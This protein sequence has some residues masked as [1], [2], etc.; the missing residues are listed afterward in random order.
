MKGKLIIFIKTLYLIAKYGIPKYIL[1]FGDSLG[2][3]LLLTVLTQKIFQDLHSTVWIK[4][5]HNTLFENNNTIKHILPYNLPLTS[6]ALKLFSIKVVSLKYTQTLKNEDRDESP[7]KN[8]VLIMADILNLKGTILN[9]P[10]LNL[11]ANE[12]QSGVIT[13]KQIVIVG[14]VSNALVAMK[15][16]E[17]QFE[18]YQQVINHFSE[19]YNFIQL[20]SISDP[21][22]DN[23]IDLR[24][25]TTIR[26]SAAILY[27][28][29]LL[30][31]YVGF[32]MHL[33][34]AVNCR[35]VILYGGREHPSQS[36]YTCNSNIYTN[37][38]CSPCWIHNDCKNNMRCMDLISVQDVIN[39]ATY[40]IS[41]TQKPL[42]VD[43]LDNGN[44]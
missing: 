23:V 3:N 2:D 10:T 39:A 7:P 9:K 43:F 42:K 26:E 15:T 32:M 38:E 30:I 8:I 19:Q 4:S 11:L 36:G 27:N 22:F 31:S 13:K 16:K 44:D 35:S 37:L 25:K 29:I 40:Q 12:K 24:G 28:S 21:K 17:W 5:N 14:S 1:C 18:R 20:G 6:F 34:R 41:Q 33:A